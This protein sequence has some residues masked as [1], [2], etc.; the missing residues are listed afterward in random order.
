MHLHFWRR[1][2]GEQGWRSDESALLPLLWPGFDSR[3]RRDM[4]GEFVVGSHPSSRPGYSGFPPSTKINTPNSNLIRKQWVKSHSVKMPLQ[5]PI[6][7]IIIA[8][9]KVERKPNFVA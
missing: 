2:V 5:I 6:I 8:F 3:T 1:P 9:D 7:I 4:W